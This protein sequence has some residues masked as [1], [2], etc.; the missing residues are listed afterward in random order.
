[1]SRPDA[2]ASSCRWVVSEVIHAALP[3][4]GGEQMARF[5]QGLHPHRDQLAVEHDGR[6]NTESK[7]GDTLLAF[8]FLGRK[9]HQFELVFGA[10]LTPHG[11]SVVARRAL[12]A[13]Q[14]LYTHDCVSCL[15]FFSAPSRR[16]AKSKVRADTAVEAG[17]QP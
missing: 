8:G 11:D 2:S 5:G 6:Q 12:R 14:Q 15:A 7:R 13:S 17:A 1:M 10:C 16:I 3:G 4:L 9:N